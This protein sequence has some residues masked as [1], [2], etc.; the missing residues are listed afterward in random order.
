MDAL[1]FRTPASSR[2]A[3]LLL[4]SAATLDAQLRAEIEAMLRHAFSTGLD[5]PG[6]LMEAVEK[7]NFGADLPLQD[8]R[9][10][11]PLPALAELH[12]QLA[13][14]VSPA[15]PGTLHL[16]R[17]DLARAGFLHSM[18][19]PLANIRRLMVAALVWMV[20]FMLISLSPTV[21]HAAMSADIYSMHGVALLTVLCFLVSAAGL[22]STFHALFTAQTY[23]SNATY[24]PRYDASY[25]I[26]IGLGLVAGLLL[27]VLV[28]VGTGS[29]A[30][31]MAKPV[32]ALLGGFSAGLVYRIL[33]R[34]V[35]TVESLFQGSTRKA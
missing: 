14:L 2:R 10:D 29:T 19:G 12:G 3:P 9:N 5:V 11:M 21:D 13:K 1:P 25:W 31:T 15:M 8:G 23:V 4:S 22:G 30:P 16:L 17:T 6:A 27:S 34:L 7:I 26:R 32:M 24:D 35:E 18:L 28:P 33:Q 20:S